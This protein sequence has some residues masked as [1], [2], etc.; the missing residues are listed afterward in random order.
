M[1]LSG[2]DL[3]EAGHVAEAYQYVNVSLSSQIE[4]GFWL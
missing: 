4:Y 1:V 2:N 3:I